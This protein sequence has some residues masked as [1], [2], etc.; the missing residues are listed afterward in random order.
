[1]PSPE[2]GVQ[3]GLTLVVQPRAFVLQWLCYT[4]PCR[5]NSSIVSETVIHSVIAGGQVWEPLTLGLSTPAMRQDHQ[6]K[7]YKIPCQD[8]T[9]HL[10]NRKLQASALWKVVPGCTK[11]GEPLI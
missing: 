11:G 9:P 2:S 10:Q 8:L 4:A 3:V 6:E 5:E 1:M 7:F